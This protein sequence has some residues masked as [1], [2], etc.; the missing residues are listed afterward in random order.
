MS[1]IGRIEMLRHPEMSFFN[2]KS[3]VNLPRFIVRYP[4]IKEQVLSTY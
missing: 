4:T 3:V 2:L 1:E